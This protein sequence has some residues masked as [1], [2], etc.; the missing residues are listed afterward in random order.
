LTSDNYSSGRQGNRRDHTLDEGKANALSHEVVD[1]LIAAVGRAE[2]E[3]SAI[4]V[5]SLSRSVLL[6]ASESEGG[7]GPH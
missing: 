3:A 5:P 4:P 6:A 7:F 1:A 2:R